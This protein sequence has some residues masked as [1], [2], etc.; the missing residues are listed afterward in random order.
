MLTLKLL[1]HQAVI[2]LGIVIEPP[3]RKNF[4]YG[5]VGVMG[6]KKPGHFQWAVNKNIG[7]HPGETGLERIENIEHEPGRG[8]Y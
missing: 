7:F 2:G 1:E 5:D 3:V 8:P 6:P 4:F